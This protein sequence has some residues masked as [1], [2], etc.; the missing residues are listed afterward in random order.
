MPQKTNSVPSPS[1]TFDPRRQFVRVTRL[2]LH[3][4]VEFEFSIGAPELCV[5]LMLRPAAFDEFCATQKVFRL[6]DL[7]SS[8]G[9]E[10][11]STETG[12]TSL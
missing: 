10:V 8:S 2:N 4:F 5:E 11:L 9:I 1:A 7:G 6:D 3:G 12:S